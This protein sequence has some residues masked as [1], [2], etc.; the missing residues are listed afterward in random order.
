VNK[1]TIH[2]F[3]IGLG[4][5]AIGRPHYIN[6]RQEQPAEFS[7]EAFR[8]H[9]K[10]VLSEAYSQGIR[11]FD[12]APG[13]G[14]AEQILLEWLE[15]NN[16]PD[17]EVATKWG[18]TYTANFDA[19]AEIHEV[20]EHSLSK[21]LEQWEVSK[22]FIPCLATYQVHSATLESGVLENK[23]VLDQLGKLKEEYN[24]RMG[25][26]TSGANQKEIIEKALKIKRNKQRLFDVYQVTYNIFDQS[27]AATICLLNAQ[28]I[29]VVIKE[30]MANG[31]LIPR[32]S[33]RHYAKLYQVV[34]TLSEKYSV[35]PDAIAI[36]FI[37]DSIR[38]FMVLSGAS[39]INHVK[40]NL[41]ATSFTLKPDEI[42][43][44]KHHRVPPELYWSERKK[45]SWN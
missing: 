44:L 18:Y 30:A 6:L 21:L 24:I 45:L 7:L 41:S 27:L 22:Q 34:K 33:Y 17:V 13:Y 32:D 43:R 15:E 25:I 16:P 12:T 23:E 1:S 38:P 42:E 29:R 28:N 4:M 35:G 11:Y 26:T 40:Q 9:G 5:A 14:I 10:K 3:P 8:Q 39:H 20:K 31:R 36:R 37:M 2:S 19:G